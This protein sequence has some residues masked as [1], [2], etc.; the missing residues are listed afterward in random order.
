[1]VLRPGERLVVERERGVEVAVVDIEVGEIDHR[2]GQPVV[3]LG[4]DLQRAARGLAL[5][6]REQR[7][8]LEPLGPLVAIVLR[9]V[10]VEELGDLGERGRGRLELRE[11]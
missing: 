6:D 2:D 5:A 9:E 1:M 8:R 7:A 3:A 11:P 10:A 4:H